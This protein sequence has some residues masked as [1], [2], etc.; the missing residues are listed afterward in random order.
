MDGG[1]EEAFAAALVALAV[2][3]VL[4]DVG[5]NIAKLPQG[6]TSFHPIVLSIYFCSCFYETYLV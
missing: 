6:A 2:T 3:G 1:V 4:F 5:P